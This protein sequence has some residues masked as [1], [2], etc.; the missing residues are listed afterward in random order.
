MKKQRRHRG[1]TTVCLALT[2]SW[3]GVIF[4]HLGH[5]RQQSHAACGELRV[6]MTTAQSPAAEICA[7]L[8]CS[9]WTYDVTPHSPSPDFL[10]LTPMC[11]ATSTASS[12]WGGQLA[13]SGC[14][15]G[16]SLIRAALKQ[17]KLH[18]MNVR[19]FSE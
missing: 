11:N 6:K 5:C 13:A 12:S 4:F 1:H 8:L 18:D 10:R 15:C 17:H 14:W 16:G 9:C 19:P 3:T 2:S 7:P